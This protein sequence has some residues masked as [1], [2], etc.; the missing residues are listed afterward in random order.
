MEQIASSL[1]GFNAFL[2][3]LAA[4]LLLGAWLALG[5]RQSSLHRGLAAA[6]LTCSAAGGLSAVGYHYLAGP[7]FFYGLGRIRLVYFAVLASRAL[8]VAIVVPLILRSLQLAWKGRF[9]E[10]S[11]LARLAIP[12]WLYASAASVAVYGMLHRMPT[13]GAFKLEERLRSEMSSPGAPAW[14]GEYA[15]DGGFHGSEDIL[16]LG[17]AGYVRRGSPMSS[18]YDWGSVEPRNDG[19]FLLRSGGW[20]SGKIVRLI[21][22]DDRVYAVFEDDKLDFVGS[23]N[24]SL[25]LEKRDFIRHVP[26]KAPK[27][28]RGGFLKKEVAPSG[29]PIVPEDWRPLLLTRPVDAVI[30]KVGSIRYVPDIYPRRISVELNAGRDSGLAPGMRLQLRN[31]G[32]ATEI[33]LTSVAEKTST[34][35]AWQSDVSRSF[36]SQRL[37]WVGQKAVSY[38][39]YEDIWDGR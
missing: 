31:F 17:T 26:Y 11:R 8:T 38:F 28:R 39:V 23:V 9:A 29:L 16:M 36:E 19:A 30:T 5:R 6:A 24:K 7:D 35:D 18:K 33:V 4:I 15:D 10:Y 12:L 37:P 3:G 13:P 27:D 20:Q 21:P 2:D 32:G 34:G 14:V 22:W 25:S 1:P